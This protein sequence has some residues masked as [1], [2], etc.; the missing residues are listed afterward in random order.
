[1]YNHRT[2]VGETTR[3]D[4]S[5]KKVAGEGVLD[6]TNRLAKKI[7]KLLD[8]HKIG[9]SVPL[10]NISGKYGYSVEHDIEKLKAAYIAA[11]RE[12]NGF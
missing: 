1:M 8:G 7:T 10:D 9:E 3:V 4:N 6:T 5:R 12:K 2:P 11:W